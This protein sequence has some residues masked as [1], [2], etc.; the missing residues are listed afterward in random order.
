MFLVLDSVSHRV[1]WKYPG[2]AFYKYTFLTDHFP[3]SSWAG[4]HRLLSRASYPTSSN[5]PA[6]KG[7]SGLS[8]PSEDSNQ[9]CDPL[10]SR[11]AA[12]FLFDKP[13]LTGLGN[14]FSKVW[15]LSFVSASCPDWYQQI[16]IL[17]EGGGSSLYVTW[18]PR[19]SDVCPPRRLA[20]Y[21]LDLF[22]CLTWPGGKLCSIL[23]RIV[24]NRGS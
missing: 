12:H 24:V 16:L 9:G 1:F 19:R 17:V 8:R 10:P 13:W 3:D 14:R 21:I 15:L 4:S 2:I 20:V 23:S 22:V 7:R 11:L 6:N 18:R 5:S